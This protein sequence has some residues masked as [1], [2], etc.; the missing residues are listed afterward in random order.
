MG[1]AG[2]RVAARTGALPAAETR[3]CLANAFDKKKP[4]VLKSA[5]AI[6]DVNSRDFEF[7]GKA[8]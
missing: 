4:P 6:I 7:I 5:I 2:G 3:R 1:L 8:S